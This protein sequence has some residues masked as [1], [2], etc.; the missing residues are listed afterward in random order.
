MES[1]AQ[2]P[3]PE[4][5]FI[6]KTTAGVSIMATQSQFDKHWKSEFIERGYAY[7]AFPVEVES[8]G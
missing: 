8:N 5:T 7:R 1:Q 2:D 3:K 4:P 6:F